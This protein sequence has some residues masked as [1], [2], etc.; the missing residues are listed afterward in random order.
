MI[1]SDTCVI[2]MF[3]FPEIIETFSVLYRMMDSRVNMFGKL[4]RLQGK[5][6]LMLSQIAT[7]T[8]EEEKPVT[9]Q[10]LLQYEEGRHFS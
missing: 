8:Q 10:P 6:D 9:Q 3:Q 4:S 7:Q 1:S 2:L 5:L